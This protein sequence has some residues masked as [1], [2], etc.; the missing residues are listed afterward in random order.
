MT[1]TRR[2]TSSRFRATDQ[3]RPDQP[4]LVLLEV[5]AIAT[6]GGYDNELTS[7]VVGPPVK[8]ATAG[9]RR[10]HCKRRRGSVLHKFTARPTGRGVRHS[11]DWMEERGAGPAAPTL[12]QAGLPG[13]RRAGSTRAKALHLPGARDRLWRQVVRERHPSEPHHMLLSVCSVP[14]PGHEE[15]S[16]PGAAQTQ[17]VRSGHGGSDTALTQRTFPSAP[18]RS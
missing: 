1:S 12:R 6:A 3:R 13:A 5:G 11:M 18:C 15:L 9:H 4:E 2:S 14:S 8:R 10:A 17:D 7:V 16:G